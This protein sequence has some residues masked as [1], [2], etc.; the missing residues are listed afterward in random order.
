MDKDTEGKKILDQIAIE[1]FVVID[2]SAYA[3]VRE[4][5]AWEKAVKK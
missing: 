2:D 3:S 1:K 5:T 4:M